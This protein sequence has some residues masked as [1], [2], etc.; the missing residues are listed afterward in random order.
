M[1]LNTYL[2]FDGN[3]AQAFHYYEQHLGGRITMMV[4]RGDA[5]EAGEFPPELRDSVL[6]ARIA[7][8]GTELQGADMPPGIQ[9]PM[10]SAYLSLS[11]DSVEEAERIYSALGEGGEILMPMDETFFAQRFAVLRDRYGMLWMIILERA[12][13]AQPQGR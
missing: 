7:L 4:H 11:V 10:R 3:C 1:K 6:H 9:K 2:N 12:G 13:T 8:A 5:P